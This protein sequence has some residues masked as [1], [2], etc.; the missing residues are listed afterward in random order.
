LRIY[1]FSIIILLLSFI[2]VYGLT[3]EISLVA[4][5]PFGTSSVSVAGDSE[6]I[7]HIT[8]GFPPA[9]TPSK[10]GELYVL[11]SGNHKVLHYCFK[12]KKSRILIK[13]D[14][15]FFAKDIAIFSGSLIVIT[16]L[17]SALIFN[18]K[19]KKITEIEGVFPREIGGN[20][21]Y[22]LIYNESTNMVM[23]FDSS[24]TLKGAL[25]GINFYPITFDGS[26]IIGTKLSDNEYYIL[27]MGFD[28]V[29]EMVFSGKSPKGEY[30]CNVKPA[31]FDSSG[32]LYF[33]ILYGHDTDKKHEKHGYR[34]VLN[35]L[36][37]K[38]GKIVR[39]WTTSPFR[40]KRTMTAPRQYI[41]SPSGEL[42]T[43]ELSPTSY[44][45]YR[46]AK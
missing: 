34:M 17:K 9:F 10:R 16:E 25:E 40:N 44:Q 13:Y 29:S 11:S 22:L 4:E 20:E 27:K 41:L 5:F 14:S 23:K 21:K 6:D 15:D 32:A 2:P 36:D 19:G 7:D 42:Y 28:G 39:R 1:T 3:G 46:Y 18:K 35:K 12:S 45:I 43:Y 37:I 24:F 30:I 31:G 38:S 33:E 8:D 26:S